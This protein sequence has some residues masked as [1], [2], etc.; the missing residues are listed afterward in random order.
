MRRIA[1][2]GAAL[3]LAACTAL[4]PPAITLSRSE[5]AERAFIDRQSIDPKRVFKGIE[6]LD[7]TGPDVG[8]QTTAQ[9]IEL[10][11]S[12]R[13]A[14][15]PLGLPL[16]LR[17][18]LSGAPVL[19]AQGNGIDLAEVRIEEVRLPSVPFLNLDTRSMNESGDSL[20]TL[21]LLQFRPDELNRDGVVYRATSISLGTF[22]LRVDLVPK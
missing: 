11:W 21:P 15:G 18:S 20:G 17:M 22:G 4:G 14:D 10:A 9:R 3:A 6:G 16:A 5:I 1:L 2:I 12:A 8:F 13:L 7:I 19:N